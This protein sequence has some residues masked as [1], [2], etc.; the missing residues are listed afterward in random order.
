[1][2]APGKRLFPLLVEGVNIS[3]SENKYLK[4]SNFL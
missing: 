4:N 2:V 3:Q 1:M